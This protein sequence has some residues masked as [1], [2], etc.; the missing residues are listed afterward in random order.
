MSI[1]RSSLELDLALVGSFGLEQQLNL[2]ERRGTEL[3]SNYDIIWTNE[4]GEFMLNNGVVS[5]LPIPSKYIDVAYMKIVAGDP[6]LRDWAQGKV[7]NPNEPLPSGVPSSTVVSALAS[8]LLL[9]AAA[10]LV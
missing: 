5:E 6:M 7:T 2:M 4:V 8:A 1:P 9:A 10:Y 3:L